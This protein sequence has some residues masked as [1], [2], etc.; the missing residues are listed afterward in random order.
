MPEHVCHCSVKIEELS[1]RKGS[2]E[3]LNQVNLTANHGEILALIGRN[4][5]GKT[6]LLKA[7]LGQTPYSGRI[8]YFNCQGKRIDRPRIGYVPQFLAFDRSTPVTV[9]DLF[10]ANRS[11]I[12]VWMSHGK[13]RQKEAESLLEKVGG[14]GMFRKKLG[15]LSG[16]ELQRVLL[17]FALDP[18][19]DLLLLDEPVSAVDRKGVG[20]FYDLVTSL[21]SEYHMPVILVSHDL[22]HVKKYASK[23]AFLQDGTV[24][25][26]NTVD[27][28]LN[29]P[30]VREAFGLD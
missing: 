22:G 5:A 7:I 16:G 8:S 23:A 13:K 21:R 26:Q 2:T 11:R 14:T 3:I 30:Q 10:C 9:E 4:G 6:T 1:V 15:A 28:V 12:P 20:V 27:K 17:A 19:P 24:A 29:N 25:M 18:L